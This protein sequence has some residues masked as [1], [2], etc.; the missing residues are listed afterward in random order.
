MSVKQSIDLDSPPPVGRVL[1]QTR[2][3]GEGSLTQQVYRLLRDCIVT[4]RILPNQFLSEKDVAAS[5][6]ISKTPVREAFIRLADDGIVRIVPKSGTYVSHVDFGRAHEGYF[7]W[8]SLEAACAAEVA[9]KRTLQDVVFLKDNLRRQKE[10][11]ENGDHLGFYHNDNEFHDAMFAIAGYPSAK[12]LIETAK[13]EVD[14]IRNLK[15]LFGLPPVDEVYTEHEAVVDAIA[16]KDPALA[17]SRMYQ[18]LSRVNDSLESLADN[19]DLWELFHHLSHPETGRRGPQ[20]G[21][22][23]PDAKKGRK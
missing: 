2:L 20:K 23:E 3:D 5:L 18:H 6:E 7:I 9:A 14:R 19:P 21:K 16:K 11:L 22:T 10:A 4:L 1:G 13:F 17:Q 12:K 8:R 15:M